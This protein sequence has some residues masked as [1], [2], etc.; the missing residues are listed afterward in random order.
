MPDGKAL[1]RGEGD[2][3]KKAPAKKDPAKKDPAE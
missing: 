2:K 1:G 3:K